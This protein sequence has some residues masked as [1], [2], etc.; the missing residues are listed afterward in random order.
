MKGVQA[1]DNDVQVL[2]VTS[3]SYDQQL[4]VL[5]HLGVDVP[6]DSSS[7]WCELWAVPL[8]SCALEERL[9][10][11]RLMSIRLTLCGSRTMVH[12]CSHN[13]VNMTVK[14]SGHS[15]RFALND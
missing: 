8:P 11:Q 6:Q 2:I 14:R 5:Q 13:L 4:L 1:D 9:F 3:D 10:W 7:R 12:Q 15:S